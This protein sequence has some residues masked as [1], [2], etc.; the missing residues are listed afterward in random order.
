MKRANWKPIVPNKMSE[1]SFW[2][3]CQ[4][5]RL[6]SDDIFSVLNTKFSSKP[7]PKKDTANNNSLDRPSTSKKEHIALRVL[8]SKAA[9]NLL[10]LY[11]EFSFLLDY[12]VF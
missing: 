6:A 9:Q 8:D 12:S 5:Q 1:K 10:I 7:A 4:E 11:G 3:K 2:V